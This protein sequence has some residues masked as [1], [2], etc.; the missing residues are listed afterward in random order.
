MACRAVLFDTDGTLLDTLKDIAN[1]ANRV[2]AR[3]GFPQHQLEAYKYLVGDG[4]E[5]LTIRIIP[6]NHRDE[7]TIAKVAE[8]ID[9]EYGRHWADTT[10]PYDGIPELLQALTM[11]SIKQEHH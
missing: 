5:A 6:D 10:R 3:F 8:E 2:L 9:S 4:M 1:S 7:T 11:R